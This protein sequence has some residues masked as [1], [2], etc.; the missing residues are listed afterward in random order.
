LLDEEHHRRRRSRLGLRGKRACAV[1]S[2]IAAGS[3]AARAPL[4]ARCRAVGV[5]REMPVAESEQG[6]CPIRSRVREPR[7]ALPDHA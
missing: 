2:D 1:G 7:S 3:R 5:I 6:S 4:T